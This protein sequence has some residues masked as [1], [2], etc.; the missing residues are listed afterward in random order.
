MFERG[1]ARGELRPDFRMDLAI[2]WFAGVLVLYAV[3]ERPVPQPDE[4]E[5]L[6][7]FLLE[8]IAAR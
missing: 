8:G 3:I 4:A 1:I 6:I 5:D 2:N 7:D